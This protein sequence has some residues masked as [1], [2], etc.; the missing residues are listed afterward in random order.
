VPLA[1]GPGAVVVNSQTISVAADG[2]VE[3]PFTERITISGSFD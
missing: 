2:T 1:A 3:L